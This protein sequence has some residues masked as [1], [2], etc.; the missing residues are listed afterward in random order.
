MSLETYWLVVAPGLLLALSAVGWA[1][2]WVTRPSP[3]EQRDA[4][5]RQMEAAFRKLE[6]FEAARTPAAEKPVD[7]AEARPNVPI[8]PQPTRQ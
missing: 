2:L 8:R 6:A 3:G 7:R 5:F 4:L 1:W